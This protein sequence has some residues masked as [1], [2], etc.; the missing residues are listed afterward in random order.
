MVS[1]NIALPKYYKLVHEWSHSIDAHCFWSVH[2]WLHMFT[3]K[4]N[5]INR[6]N[7]FINYIVLAQ[8]IRYKTQS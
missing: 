5:L 1:E 7:V 8:A 6:D 2:S 4:N 3:Y